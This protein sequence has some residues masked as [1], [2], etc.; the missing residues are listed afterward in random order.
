MLAEMLSNLPTIHAAAK[1]GMATKPTL[2]LLGEKGPEMVVPMKS[3][4]DAKMRPM[5]QTRSSGSIPKITAGRAGSGRNAQHLSQVAK[6]FARQANNLIQAI[7][8]LGPTIDASESSNMEM[9]SERESYENV[10]QGT[11]TI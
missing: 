8:S 7:V 2:T 9:Q 10:I 3:L 4:A 1:G 5:S 11:G 6:G